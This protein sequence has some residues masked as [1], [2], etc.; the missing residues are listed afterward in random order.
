MSA[1]AEY[2]WSICPKRCPCCRKKTVT[3]LG[4]MMNETA[5]GWNNVMAQPSAERLA[6]E[7]TCPWCG[8]KTTIVARILLARF[9]PTLRAYAREGVIL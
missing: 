1:L 3:V 9:E 4:P 7:G 8:R 6:R 5:Q 2:E